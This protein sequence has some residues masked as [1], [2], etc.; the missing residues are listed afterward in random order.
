M[1]VLIVDDEIMI[2][3][4]LKSA[5][6]WEENGFEVIGEA[7][8]GEEALNIF[9]Q[10]SPDI[11]LTDIKM[12]VM[13]GLQLIKEVKRLDKHVKIIILSSYNEFDMVKIALRLGA[14]DYLLKVEF[15]ENDLLERAI[16]LKNEL[17]QVKREKKIVSE[18]KNLNMHTTRVKLLQ[19]IIWGGVR[20]KEEIKE[21][22][23][24]CDINI[25]LESYIFLSI[26]IDDIGEVEKNW[27]NNKDGLFSLSFI[28]IV[29][30]NI[31]NFN[32]GFIFENENEYVAIVN[33]CLKSEVKVYERIVSICDRIKNSI[34]KYLNVSITIGVSNLHGNV[35]EM[36]K[37]YNEAIEAIKRHFFIGKGK[38]IFYD[39]GYTSVDKSYQVS[40]DRSF[41]E[42]EFLRAMESLDKN[43]IEEQMNL[44]FID[45][46]KK[47]DYSIE[48]ILDNV[49]EF[50]YSF[51]SIVS[52]LGYDINKVLEQEYNPVAIT[53]SK[54]TFDEL[55]EEIKKIVFITLDNITKRKCN[56]VTGHVQRALDF[57]NEH[58][59][60]NI[61][62]VTV[63][64]YLDMNVSYLSNLFNEEVGEHFSD[65][66]TK[67][68]IM[69]AKK[70]LIQKRF[71]IYEV[72]QMV[73]YS[74]EP[75][76]STVFKKVTGLNAK[77]YYE[78]IK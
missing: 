65:Y 7:A 77:D 70:L 36:E 1:K 61:G 2:R 74:N 55:A 25:N 64:N 33:I 12:P 60:E 47:S 34:F 72:A 23:E 19:D 42:K 41:A 21:K 38:T 56:L 43:K 48:K 57:I 16:S 40:T 76:F 26:K 37:A 11:I 15:N 20:S 35:F 62:L 53:S 45:V 67:I 58:Y 52:Y 75:Y 63:A 29:E 31:N 28:N 27:K 46:S 24:I 68:R 5:I 4:G 30:E 39:K 49:T 3:V 54:R 14:D 69:N 71:K 17:L 50:L 8:N 10:K 13:D 51:K 73:G 6:P 32:S 18:V 59:S 78:S 44:F 66:L 22:L 9:K